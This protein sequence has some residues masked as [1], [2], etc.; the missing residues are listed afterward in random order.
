MD[1]IFLSHDSYEYLEI[2]KIDIMKIIT[3]VYNPKTL[4]SLHA[5]FN[6]DNINSKLKKIII[7]MKQYI[8]IN[9]FSKKINKINHLIIEVRIIFLLNIINKLHKN[10]IKINLFINL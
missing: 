4:F 3:G 10:F 9:A 6:N 8:E 1:F 5:M 2:S 7:E